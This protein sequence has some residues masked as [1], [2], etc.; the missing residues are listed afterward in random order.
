MS[1]TKIRDS[2]K[3]ERLQDY[4]LGDCIG[5][6]GFG[7]VYKAINLQDGTV[8]AVK[9]IH[10]ENIPKSKQAG[11]MMEIDL[12][13]KLSHPCIVKYLGFVDTERDLN[14]ILE[15]VENGSLS[16]I[17]HK[18]GQFPESLTSVYMYQTLDGLVY[19]HEQG[20]IHRD[21]KGANIL[22]TKEGIV[23]LADFG[24]ATKLADI[25]Q[26]AVVGTPYWMAPEII[27][28]TGATTA[29][30]IWS[31]GCTIIELLEGKPPYFEFPPMPALFHIVQDDH[32][33]LPEGISPALRDFLTQCFQKEPSLRVT[34]KKLMR[35][36]WL[37]HH[38]K[39]NKGKNGTDSREGSG[40]A[41][42]MNELGLA[43]QVEKIK[44]FNSELENADLKVGSTVRGTSS[45]MVSHYRGTLRQ[46]TTR[47]FETLN[48]RGV[49]EKRLQGTIKTSRLR[50][51]GGQRPVLDEL[52]DMM[53]E[54]APEKDQLSEVPKV[55]G[56]RS[57]RGTAGSG[58]K[59]RPGLFNIF[60]GEEGKAA[61]VV[62]AVDAGSKALPDSQ[63]LQ[64]YED[65]SGSEEDW[66]DDFVGDLDLKNSNLQPKTSLQLGG[67]TLKPIIKEQ[68]QPI[69]QVPKGI[70]RWASPEPGAREPSP[71][72]TE[73]QRA[74][75]G[76]DGVDVW[77]DDFL[78]DTITPDQLQG[79]LKF[80]GGSQLKL[81]GDSTAS[82]TVSS[83]ESGPR[84]FE[85]IK[86]TDSV[87]EQAKIQMKLSPIASTDTLTGRSGDSKIST[88]STSKLKPKEIDLTI[89]KETE[90]ENDFDDLG[91]DDEVLSGLDK[92]VKQK[93]ERSE[94]TINT[95]DKFPAR[96]A[97][98]T[99]KDDKDSGIGT[100][101]TATSD[102]WESGSNRESQ[103]LAPNSAKVERRPTSGRASMPDDPRWRKFTETKADAADWT[104]DFADGLEVGDNLTLG[105]SSS[106]Q[107]ISNVDVS[108]ENRQ[109]SSTSAALEE[110]LDEEDPF[111]DLDDDDNDEG[112]E[113]DEKERIYM[114]HYARIS[115]EIITLIGNLK[116]GQPEG[117]LLLTC[118]RLIEIFT[119]DPSQRV[120]L[121]A[122][123]GVIPIME[124]LEIGD[125]MHV[126]HGI[127]QVVN[128]IIED[129]EDIQENLCLVGGIPAIMRFTASSYSREVRE[130]AATFIAHMCQTSSLTM[131]M[132]IA[133]RGLPVLV[134]FLD[135]N[136]RRSP[137]LVC[138][139]I[140]Q[141]WN[142]F[143]LQSTTPKSDFCRLFAKNGLLSSLA[144]VLSDLTAMVNGST[145]NLH[146][147]SH[148]NTTKGSQ[149]LDEADA[150]AYIERVALIMLFFSNADSTVKGIMASSTVLTSIF[151]CMEKTP[152]KV[153]HTLLK[154]I[155]NL[156]MEPIC[157]DPLQRAG[158][159]RVLVDILTSSKYGVTAVTS[160]QHQLNPTPATAGV[161]GNAPVSHQ[162]LTDIHNQVLNA[163]FN[164]CRINR[165]RQEEA[166]RSGAIPSLMHFVRQR[167][168]LKQLALNIVVDIAQA[169]A[170]C[171][172]Y[173]W[174][175]E[176]IPFFVSLL[177]DPYWQSNAMEILAL[178]AQDAS[179]NKT[180]TH[181]RARMD[182]A[183]IDP[184][185]MDVLTKM[186]RTA[187]SPSFDKTLDPLQR[188]ILSSDSIN[189]AIG[190]SK[191]V[192]AL[193]AR[194]QHPKAQ[195]R[196]DLLKILKVLFAGTENPRQF[197]NNNPMMYTVL[198]DI[199][200]KDAAVMTQTLAEN[201]IRDMDGVLSGKDSKGAAKEGRKEDLTASSNDLPGQ[202]EEVFD[203][204]ANVSDP[205]L[206]SPAAARK[207]QTSPTKQQQ[208]NS[209][210]NA[211]RRSRKFRTHSRNGSKSKVNPDK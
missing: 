43:N 191:M 133:C 75:N 12:L 39:R 29:S 153:M 116:P 15:Y 200:M 80:R 199:A 99:L 47:R 184:E 96:G 93:K 73:D 145:G 113:F 59:Q 35:H 8:V 4:I 144:G 40:N 163:L 20:V 60:P 107:M 28:L 53:R 27:I 161:K 108:G 162:S 98:Q 192:T 111:A 56:G 168:P 85:T 196:G 189:R 204:G 205:R 51:R 155:K 9:K 171:R 210:P 187:R 52:A 123:H 142:V 177:N 97:L 1:K 68:P 30:D 117:D 74:P 109:V 134:D 55:A 22:T 19:L 112:L 152:Q 104:D 36:A 154:S 44:Q 100:S 32:P 50:G 54:S 71:E 3:G 178:G 146:V 164:L 79:A 176:G 202:S 139:A 26:D 17:C 203:S 132:F 148:G 128:T 180:L 101:T 137:Y 158:A 82:N 151:N 197:L 46:G 198:K 86:A 95:L 208:G 127:L 143:E 72:L 119:E 118:S 58:A 179:T 110:D 149:Q 62:S 33:P 125:Q 150:L 76:E 49:A 63:S 138:T 57:K 165:S 102:T 173:L 61:Q 23:K 48:Q 38:H 121:I 120:E 188:L 211:R 147:G 190:N 83:M 136:V 70:N 114:D 5:K 105:M 21:I 89:Y 182:E 7:A 66:D 31:L 129:A 166:A 122:H 206:G 141:I 170:N 78:V 10:T 181:Q 174:Q 131:Q 115:N 94:S 159:I 87:M 185:A 175:N 67:D 156:T 194:L 42:D 130:E 18:F 90:S 91:F 126:V 88:S 183:L 135:E 84:T 24:V 64:A 14:I 106:G 34:A 157:L 167:G 16:S 172:G 2:S 11:I 69:S 81:P 37:A 209:S 201:L 160:S 186:V 169:N 13:K 124:M 140:D 41:Q 193:L 103:T 6:G 92:V 25:E 45:G 65:H 77:D 207:P 195:V